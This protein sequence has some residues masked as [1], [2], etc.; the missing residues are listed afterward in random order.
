MFFFHNFND[1]KVFLYLYENDTLQKNTIIITFSDSYKNISIE[2]LIVKTFCL[3]ALLQETVS[4]K[5]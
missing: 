3:E 4:N 5:P 1:I 2:A